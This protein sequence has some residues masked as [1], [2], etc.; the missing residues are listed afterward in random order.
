M[1]DVNRSIAPATFQP[2]VHIPAKSV[3]PLRV[4]QKALLDISILLLNESL[5]FFSPMLRTI[6]F[7][8]FFLPK[9]IVNCTVERIDPLRLVRAIKAHVYAF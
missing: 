2:L 8:Y 3:F 5:Q 7:F 4:K 1:E 9:T 6:Y